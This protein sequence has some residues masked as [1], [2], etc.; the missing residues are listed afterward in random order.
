M[1]PNKQHGSSR[2][3]SGKLSQAH[4]VVLIGFAPPAMWGAKGERWEEPGPPFCK[5]THLNFWARLGGQATASIAAN[6]NA[7]WR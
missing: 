1:E 2:S 5:P 7:P 6:S 4:I 3:R